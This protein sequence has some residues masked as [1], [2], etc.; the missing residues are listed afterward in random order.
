MDYLFEKLLHDEESVLDE[1]QNAKELWTDILDETP[2]SDTEALAARLRGVQLEF[3][4]QC[5]GELPGKELMGVVA[6]Y[7]FYST[8]N[9]FDDEART[10]KD[11]LEAIKRS[12]CS[13]EVEYHAKRVAD[14]LALSD[15]LDRAD[16]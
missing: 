10:A 11:V 15:E 7:Q 6:I 13:S 1:V 14:H 16:G 5:G 2:S 9:G 12:K 8:A 4:D 3:E